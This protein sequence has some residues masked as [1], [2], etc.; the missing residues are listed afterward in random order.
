MLENK[1]R[2]RKSGKT[3]DTVSTMIVLV[4]VSS[5]TNGTTIKNR[6]AV[7]IISIFR[8]KESI[9]NQ[10]DCTQDKESKYF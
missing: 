7:H 1:N 6:N 4:V 8:F 10:A 2:Q 3:R 5:C 9:V